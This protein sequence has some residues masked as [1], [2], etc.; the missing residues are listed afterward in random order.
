MPAP[1]GRIAMAFEVGGERHVTKAVGYDCDGF[2]LSGRKT[3]ECST[4][5]VFGQHVADEVIA[6]GKSCANQEF[7]PRAHKAPPNIISMCR[8]W[9]E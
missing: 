7:F 9:S 1:V 3:D 5:G 2:V 4:F 8:I 6:M